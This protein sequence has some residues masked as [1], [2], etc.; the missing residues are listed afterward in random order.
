MRIAVLTFL[1]AYNYGAELQ[2]FALQRKLLSLGYDTEVLDVYRPMNEEFIPSDNFKQLFSEE[3]K[4]TK[5]AKTN[6]Y[7]VRQI[8]KIAKK[9]YQTREKARIEKFKDFQRKFINVSETKYYNFDAIYEELFPYTHFIVGSD[10]VWNFSNPFSTEPYFLTYVKE[11]IKKIS[12]AASIGHEYLPKHIAE[13]YKDWLSSFHNISLREKTGADIISEL[14]GKKVSHV[15]DPTLLL[16]K[17]EWIEALNISPVKKKKPYVLVY[18]LSTS[19]Y[20]I[21]LARRIARDMDCEVKVIVPGT[22]SPYIFQK[23]LSFLYTLGP[24]DFVQLFASASFVI[25]NSFHGTAFSVNFNVPFFATPK[26]RKKT[27]SR[28]QSLLDMLGLSSRL[29]YEGDPYPEDYSM[30][31]EDVNKRLNEEREYSLNYL[32]KSLE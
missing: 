18:L 3:D 7:I 15:L 32:I 25:T 12:Y 13:K 19:Y 1:H 9:I 24:V 6:S 29:L 26:K 11:P 17:K 14:L 2:A 8:N 28:Y 10:Q 22:W 23:N 4:H 27:L 16:S 21:N 5:K 30:D 20:S 31:F